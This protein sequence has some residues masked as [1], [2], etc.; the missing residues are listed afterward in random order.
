MQVIARLRPLQHG[1]AAARQLDRQE[2]RAYELL[3]R[4]L[5]D[6]A[7]LAFDLTRDPQTRQ[8]GRNGAPNREGVP[9][10][11]PGAILVAHPRLRLRQPT[12]RMTSM[13]LSRSRSAYT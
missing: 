10:A 4:M 7:S 2:Q 6:R 9:I 3:L 8:L 12:S 5:A 13:A 1:R 11:P